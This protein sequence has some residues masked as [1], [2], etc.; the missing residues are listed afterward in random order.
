MG[1]DS[2]VGTGRFASWAGVPCHFFTVS[3]ADRSRIACPLLRNTVTDST[4]PSA[5]T[6]SP[7]ST[8]PSMR[9]RIASGGYTGLG[10]LEKSGG[11]RS[12]TPATETV[13]TAGVVASATWECERWTVSG[14][15]LNALT[16]IESCL[17][18][19]SESVKGISDLP[20]RIS[21]AR[22][23]CDGA[24][25]SSR[26]AVLR[27]KSS[28]R[29]GSTIAGLRTTS[30]RICSRIDGE[31]STGSDGRGIAIV[32]GFSGGTRFAAASDNCMESRL[33]SKAICCSCR[34]LT[35]K[36]TLNTAAW[37]TNEQ[38]EA[39]VTVGRFRLFVSFFVMAFKAG[40]ESVRLPQC[41]HGF[42]VPKRCK[43]SLVSKSRAS[44]K[45]AAF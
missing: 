16:A 3:I 4:R 26:E 27:L 35:K 25:E 23:L 43:Q 13:V 1:I 7:K 38:L 45:Y 37:T 36:I 18:E 34:L 20:F 30:F 33:P 11:V 22:G 42:L 17:L 44:T 32:T 41:S 29:S 19:R 31:A 21:S 15:G 10:L 5:V 14:D 8:V 9:C 12:F 28:L 40:I 24:V 6:S 39:C 2:L